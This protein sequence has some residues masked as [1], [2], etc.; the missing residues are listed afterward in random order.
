MKRIPQLAYLTCVG[1]HGITRKNK[2]GAGSRGYMISRRGKVVT[3]H[4]GPIVP[5]RGR[6]VRLH[7][8]RGPTEIVDTFDSIPEAEAF[9]REI[10]RQKQEPGQGYTFLRRGVKIHPKR[11]PVTG[12]ARTKLRA[13]R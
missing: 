3:R 11:S 10:L 12:A 1:G 6:G 7:W 13:R 4:Y 5:V 9:V 2:S 8:L